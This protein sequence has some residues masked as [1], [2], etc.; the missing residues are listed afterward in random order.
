MQKS[1]KEKSKDK[2]YVT[3][4][5]ILFKKVLSF[6]KQYVKKKKERNQ[7]VLIILIFSILQKNYTLKKVLIL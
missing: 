1:K 3:L 4:W 5:H 7:I 2:K 6:I